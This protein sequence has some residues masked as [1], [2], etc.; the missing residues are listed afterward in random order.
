[1]TSKYWFYERGEGDPD[2][3]PLTVR[4][5][6]TPE[7]Y[8]LTATDLVG[9]AIKLVQDH[10]VRHIPITG[11]GGALVG[12]VTE[13]DLLRKVTHARSM[14][15]DER[16]HA[17]LDTMLP[18]EEIMVR[19]VATLPPDAKVAEAVHLLLVRKFRCVPVVDGQ[20]RVMGIVTETDLMK[21]LEHMLAD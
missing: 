20:R 14:T 6:M 15:P 21:L 8:T 4:S 5:L 10:H 18:L 1:M 16:Y 3:R 12:L 13:T 17:F 9:D 2:I 11:G 19:Q 7:P